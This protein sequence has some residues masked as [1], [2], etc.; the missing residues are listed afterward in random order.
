MVGSAEEAAG[1]IR[2]RLG[3][4]ARV[5]S[6]RPSPPKASA[7]SGRSPRSR[8]SPRSSRRPPAAREPARARGPRRPA[9][10]PR[11]RPGPAP[12]A[13]REPPALSELLR[14]SGLTEM[15]LG[16]LQAVAELAELDGRPA[17]PG[18]GR[19]RP[20][21]AA[22][23]RAPR[24]GPAADPGRLPRHPRGRPHH[25]ALQMARPRGLPPGPA[26]PRRHGRIRPAQ[27]PRPASGLL[28]GARGAR[29][30]LSRDHPAGVPGGFV[31]FD[32]PGISLRNPADNAAMADF[33]P[34]SRS[35][36]GSWS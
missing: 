29:G 7:G 24:P 13:A 8:S 15:A 5:L 6:V 14:R 22:R 23:G 26:R 2:E 17:P 12:S 19:D 4:D 20:A 33:S 36:S 3:P 1:L 16:R 25:R 10:R 9:A 34:G 21:P 27:S 35:S 28:R 32:L 18:P 31:Y 30:P 11:P